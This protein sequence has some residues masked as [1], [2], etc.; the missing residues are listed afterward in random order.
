MSVE[1]V[2]GNTAKT[3]LLC[4]TSNTCIT[5]DS[6]CEPGR[7]TCES[8]GQACAELDET[9]VK[10]HGGLDGTRDEHGHDEAVNLQ[11]SPTRRVSP[12]CSFQSDTTPEDPRGLTA[13]I[14]AMTTGMMHFIIKSG[15]R[16]P[17]AAMPTPDFDVPYEAPMPV[18]KVFRCSHR[19]HQ[20]QRGSEGRTRGQEM[21]SATLCTARA[22]VGGRV[23]GC[24]MLADVQV[25]TM[26]AVHPLH[27]H[28]MDISPLHDSVSCTTRL[29]SSR[30][31][32]R[33]RMASKS[34]RGHDRTG[35]R[36]AQSSTTSI[37]TGQ[38]SENGLHGNPRRD[39]RG[40]SACVAR[41]KC[42]ETDVQFVAQGM[43]CV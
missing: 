24:P 3:D 2:H 15:L 43:Q 5:D 39:N 4:D 10:R 42:S 36:E 35:Q 7:E 30:R 6:D 34:A 14:P 11:A 13:M 40:V 25:K 29:F 33:Q 17:M 16:T 23:I 28:K 1:C 37:L 21:Q 27:E 20:H 31:T 19:V 9:G 41:R 18:G 8:D 12:V 22:R 32:L 38:P 26:A